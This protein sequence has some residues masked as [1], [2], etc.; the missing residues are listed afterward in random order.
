[1]TKVKAEGAKKS[2]AAVALQARVRGNT[3]RKKGKVESKAAV[4]L[5]ARV[6][7]NSERKKVQVELNAK[8]TSGNAKAK[9]DTGRRS[10]TRAAKEEEKEDRVLGNLLAGGK[11]PAEGSAAKKRLDKQ[12]DKRT[13]NLFSG[14]IQ[15]DDDVCGQIRTALTERLARVLDLFHAMDTDGNGH[16]DGDEFLMAL[17]EL[18][19]EAP[20]EAISAVFQSFDPDGN[21]QIEYAE[22]HNLL[23]RSVQDHP[24]LTPL[25]I[26]ATNR[27]KLRN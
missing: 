17:E 23:V 25:D 19:L 15:G 5:Q 6:R 1:M 13:G 24:T 8:A 4:A 22:M 7:G 12:L 16:V 14:A 10:P 9:V 21:G 26:R 20:E 27:I 11:A 2:K 18:G 3:E